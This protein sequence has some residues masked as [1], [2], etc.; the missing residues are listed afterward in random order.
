VR[1]FTI[2][3]AEATIDPN[4]DHIAVFEDLLVDGNYVLELQWGLFALAYPEKTIRPRASGGN[5]ETWE[6][7]ADDVGYYLATDGPGEPYTIDSGENYFTGTGAIADILDDLGLE[8]ALPA[9]TA[10]LPASKTWPSTA[11]WRDICNFLTDGVN[12]Y[13]IK[14][15]A[16]GKF[17]TQPRLD[18]STRTPD[19]I[20]QDTDWLLI[21]IQRSPDTSRFANKIIATCDNPLLSSVALNDDPDSPISTVSLGRTITRRIPVDAVADQ[22]TLDA[23]AAQYLRDAA[24]VYERVA[25]ETHPDP[26]REANE[27]YAL[28][29]DDL[30][31]GAL[32]AAQDWEVELASKPNPRMKHNVGKVAPVVVS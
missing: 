17:R 29:V 26:R 24:N 11:T 13:A 15:D 7:G 18:L 32:Y 20:Y 8:H 9:V 30:W 5:Y 2:D 16:A 28:T 27:V 6:V 22:T 10:T 31:D 12:H 25:I 19:V 21:P 4:A 23:I 1:K 3:P 14:P